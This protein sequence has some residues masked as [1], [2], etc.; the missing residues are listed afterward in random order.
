MNMALG[1]EAPLSPSQYYYRNGTCSA[2]FL[3][4][5]GT[6]ACCCSCSSKLKP[7][8]QSANMHIVYNKLFPHTHNTIYT[9]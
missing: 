5:G 9:F 4:W 6:V 3:G 1:V 8:T 7:Q 2:Q